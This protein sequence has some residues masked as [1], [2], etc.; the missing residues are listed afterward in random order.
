MV[1][2]YP[3]Q[4]D[5]TKHGFLRY[6]INSPLQEG[7]MG[8]AVILTFGVGIMIFLRRAQKAGNRA[9]EATEYRCLMGK[10]FNQLRDD[11][12]MSSEKWREWLPLFRDADDRFTETH[13]YIK[14]FGRY[15][16]LVEKEIDDL[17][18]QTIGSSQ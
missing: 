11:P 1:S 18:F 15:A 8:A 4:E 17:P 7:S 2:F 5:F 12:F 14:E 6:K 16:E 3:L 9:L 13:L 10:L